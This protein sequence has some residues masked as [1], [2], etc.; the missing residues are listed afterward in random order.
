[1]AAPLSHP[2]V[3]VKGTRD[4]LTFFLSEESSFD[5]LRGELDVKVREARGQFSVGPPIP[6]VLH[7]GRRRFSPEREEELVRVL[8]DGGSFFVREVR[9]DVFP[10]EEC[11][12]FGMRS[13]QVHLGSVRSGEHLVA[14]GDL[15]VVGD[16]HGGAKVEGREAVYILGHLSGEAL[17]R[18]VTGI[19]VA[20]AFQATLL[21]IGDYYLSGAAFP[22]DRWGLP[23]FAVQ[24][25]GKV[26]VYPYR[27]LRRFRMGDLRGCGIGEGS[28]SEE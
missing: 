4:G 17:V 6:V 23:G 16:V 2:I 14:A 7:L 3:F 15:L 26:V 27:E 22:E 21:V 25:C 10:M 18:E 20:G 5:E 1:M 9:G 19:V 11:A 13:A 12:A 24:E 28:E 8:E